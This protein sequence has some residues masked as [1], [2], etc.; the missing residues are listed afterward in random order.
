M[1]EYTAGNLL[2]NRVDK[3]YNQERI[4]TPQK[5]GITD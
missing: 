2:T 1:E 3:N 5:T 4:T